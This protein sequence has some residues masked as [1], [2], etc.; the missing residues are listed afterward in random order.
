MDYYIESEGGVTLSGGEVLSQ[1]E[2]AIE[3]LKECRKH[4]IHTACETSA[5]SSP[6]IFNNFIEYSAQF[7][8]DSLRYD[9]DA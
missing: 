9:G 3:L 4:N 5:F 6:E 8:R 7:G 1:P 2:F